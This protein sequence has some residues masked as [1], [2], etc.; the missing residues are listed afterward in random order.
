[1]LCGSALTGLGVEMLL[2][3]VLDLVEF[4][5]LLGG[6]D[7]CVTGE[8][9]ADA[10]SAHGKVV[11]G[12]A[13]RCRRAGVPCVAVTWGFRDEEELIAAEEDFWMNYV[14]KEVPPPFTENAIS[15]RT[16]CPP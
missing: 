4:D 8:G 1:M 9:H 13:A 15:R 6:C 14:Q 3:C 12:V 2:E 5:A 7:L 16:V 10:Q 11:S